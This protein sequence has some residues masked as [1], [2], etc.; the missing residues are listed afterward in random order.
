MASSW[1]TPEKTCHI[2]ATRIISLGCN[3]HRVQLKHD[4]SKYLLCGG[5]TLSAS[6]PQADAQGGALSPLCSSLG[7]SHPTPPHLH[8]LSDFLDA[9]PSKQQ[10]RQP[11][12]TDTLQSLPHI[13]SQTESLS[14]IAQLM[15]C[16]LQEAFLASLLAKMNPDKVS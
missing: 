7:V 8:R 2:R 11:G 4:Q 6:S 12:N 9:H 14:I 5:H 16:L 13:S 10:L 3:G 1:R 15:H